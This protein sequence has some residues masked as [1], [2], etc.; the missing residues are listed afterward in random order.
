MKLRWVPV[1]C[2]RN[3]QHWTSAFCLSFNKVKSN[4]KN[5]HNFL[6][7]KI[8]HSFH[9]W[10]FETSSSASCLSDLE[11]STVSWTSCARKS[12]VSLQNT[13]RFSADL[14]KSEPH[15]SFLSSFYISFPAADKKCPCWEE[16]RPL[17]VQLSTD[18]Q[19]HVAE[20]RLPQTILVRHREVIIFES[21]E[22]CSVLYWF[23]VKLMT[24]EW[25]IIILAQCV[26]IVNSGC[27]GKPKHCANTNSPC[28]NGKKKN[29]TNDGFSSEKKK[30]VNV[31][32][33]TS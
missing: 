7:W 29:G 20:D 18:L 13:C 14:M 32:D 4:K 23:C 2:K 28:E 26:L 10:I 17:P 9:L 21:F 16:V 15:T 5:I 22:L 3:V 24:R 30:T 11:I 12:Y 27:K 25:F 33:E 8:V 31:F 1:F 6:Q 19:S